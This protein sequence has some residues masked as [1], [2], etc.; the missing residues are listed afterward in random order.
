MPVS[1]AVAEHGRGRRERDADDDDEAGA[2]EPPQ[3]PPAPGC[4][5]QTAPAG[6]PSIRKVCTITSMR[7]S[8][9]CQPRWSARAAACAEVSGTA[10]GRLSSGPCRLLR[11]AWPFDP[12]HPWRV[13]RAS[14]RD[15]SSRG[16]PASLSSRFS[17][18]APAF[19]HVS[20]FVSFS[21]LSPEWPVRSPLSCFGDVSLTKA[22]VAPTLGQRG[23]GVTSRAEAARTSPGTRPSDEPASTARA[24]TLSDR[25]SAGDDEDARDVVAEEVVVIDLGAR[26]LRW[27]AEP[28][29]ERLDASGRRDDS[30]A[31]ACGT[32]AM[33]IEAL[34]C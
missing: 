21:S 18:A 34:A 13:A 3:P 33:S 16:A 10:W 9:S 28:A 24:S 7:A 29:F 1:E 8:R 17:T 19:R 11:L 27:P 25:A 20:T 30:P 23:P 26:L 14:R 12:V 2:R 32:G 4:D 31:E 15:R 5:T 6:K 22:P